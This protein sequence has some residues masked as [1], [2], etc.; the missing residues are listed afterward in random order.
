MTATQ[1]LNTIS[2]GWSENSCGLLCNPNEGGGIIDRVFLSD[3]WFVIFND[4][5]SPISGLDSRDDAVEAFA[6]AMNA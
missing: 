4:G 1:L 2:E 3:E 5:R 6:S